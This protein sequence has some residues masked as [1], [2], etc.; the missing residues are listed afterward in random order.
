[1]R[2]RR[3][4]GWHRF[5]ARN[6]WYQRLAV[7]E[8]SHFSTSAKR[9]ALF[10]YSYAALDIFKLA[11]SR[12]W[13]TILGQIDPGPAEERIVSRIYDAS[14]DQRG[15]WSPAPR[16]YWK[17]WREECELADRIV[18]NSHWSRSGLEEEGVG[19]SK[20]SIVS[21]A[22]E[23]SAAAVGFKREYPKLFTPNRPL[24]VLFLG[25]I[26][27][28]KGALPLLNAAKLL[29]EEPLEFWF[30]GP[31]QIL[32]SPG[33]QSAPNIKWFGPVARSET[34]RFY[35]EADVFIFPTCSDGF[36]LTQLEAQ[37]WQLPIIAS[38]FCGEVVRD[39]TNGILLNEISAEAIA[40]ALGS[41]LVAPERLEAMALESSLAK[42]FTW[43]V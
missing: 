34:A 36:G 38:R 35:R 25:Q 1:M 27:L 22:Y 12:G 13:R 4:G 7:Q 16:V 14:S 28:R 23:G 32:I 17:R 30:V 24:R 10:A 15:Q 11:R 9:I 5:M 26:N 2:L 21:L 42:Q 33:L 18:V 39:K 43:K 29:R 31:I 37:A 3:I 6:D 40:N 19:A 20:I 8:L 41:F